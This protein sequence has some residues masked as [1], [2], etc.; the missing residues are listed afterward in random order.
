MAVKTAPK[1]SASCKF[2]WLG[3]FL[4]RKRW[5][6]F[7]E[8]LKI[9]VDKRVK[10]LFGMSVRGERVLLYSFRDLEHYCN[11]KNIPNPKKLE[12]SKALPTNSF[13]SSKKLNNQDLLIAKH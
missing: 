7:F 13:K 1:P 9:S 12:T 4:L 8:K 3:H 2:F 10:R 11:V 5:R 6:F